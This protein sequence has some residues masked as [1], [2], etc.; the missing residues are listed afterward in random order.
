MDL[1]IHCIE[2]LE[3]IEFSILENKVGSTLSVSNWGIYQTI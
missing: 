2:I 1:N 3:F